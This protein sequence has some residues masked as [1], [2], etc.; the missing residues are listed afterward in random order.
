MR[1]IDVLVVGAGPAGSATAAH[2][3][4]LGLSVCLVDRARFPRHKAC[5]EYLSPEAARDLDALGVRAAVEAAGARR[6]FGFRLVSDD[7]ASVCGRFQGAHDFTPYRP[8]GYALPRA[9]L[10]SILLSAARDSGVHVLENTSLERLLV[11]ANGVVAGAVLLG[12][13][14]R[15]VVH[16]RAVVGADGLNSRVARQLGL[17]RRGRPERLALVAHLSGMRGLTDMGEMFAARGWYVGFAQVGEGLVNAAMVV[18]KTEA[19]GGRR[20]WGSGSRQQVEAY[21]LA[22]LRSVPELARRL[23][24]AQIA[25]EVMIAGPFARRARSV[26]APGALLVGDAAD[27]YDPFTGE[28]IFAALRGGALAAGA[29]HAALTAGEA[30][31]ESLAPYVRARR[32]EFLG[33]WLLERI[34]GLAATRPMLMRR[35]THR[36]ATR[37][38]VADLWVG[39]AGD[40]VP[41]R[42]LF[43]PRHLMALVV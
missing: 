26:V 14:G 16:S 22:K 42:A 19:A 31:M 10:D 12:D 36:L 32:S 15:V 40:T 28:G 25:R 41:V 5:A 39:A 33:K 17:M 38:D 13:G 7:G 30:T 23:E 8:F 11:G 18:P 43:A 24:G 20:Q 35:F 34:V 9:V 6:L 29:L 21:F 3:S 2:A 1:D 4:R 37:T 27:F